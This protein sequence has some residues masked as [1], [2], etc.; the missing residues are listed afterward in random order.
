MLAKAAERFVSGRKLIVGTAAVTAGICGR[1]GQGACLNKLSDG[2]EV[3][4]IEAVC[5]ANINAK[6]AVAA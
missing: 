2:E 1:R 5:R 3:L 6:V 4:P